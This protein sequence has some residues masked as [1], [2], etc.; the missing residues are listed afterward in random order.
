MKHS[1]TYFFRTAS[2]MLAAVLLTVCL[3]FSPLSVPASAD[4]AQNISRLSE[5]QRD[6][7]RVISSLALKDAYDKQDENGNHVFA[8]MT[9]GQALYE[10]GWARYG[11]SVIANNQFGIKA[12]SSWKGKVFD[13]KTYMVYDSYEA[14][15]AIEGID[16]A[17]HCNLWRAYD[18]WDESVSD[19]SAL[20][21]NEKKYAKLL[22]ASDY[23]DAARKV[24]EAG[25]CSDNG[26]DR[27]LI[28]VIEDYGLDALDGV[29]ADEYG[30][31]G[32]IMDRSRAVIG[33][34][35]TVALSASA[36]PE[37]V[38]P[39]PDPDGD[40]QEESGSE[41]GEESE[42]SAG[43]EGSGE[44]SEESG[45]GEESGD[46]SGDPDVSGPDESESGN[47][48][49]EPVVLPIVWESNAPAV[50][51]VDENGNVTGLSQGIALITATYNGKEAACLVC[52]G[53]NAFVIDSD[54]ALYSLPDP[55]SDS[56]GKVS[57]GMP[58][59][60]LEI[61][62]YEDPDGVDYYFVSATTSKGKL[63]RGYL[64]IRRVYP[65]GQE[66]T[67]LHMET[68]IQMKTGD[69][70]EVAY[71]I[72]PVTAEDKTV[73]WHTSDGSI[74]AVTGDGVLTAV[75][76]GNA[77][78]TATAVGGVTVSIIVNVDLVA[79]TGITTTALKLRENPDLESDYYGVIAGCTHVSV[80]KGP[81]DGWFYIQAE[82]I[83]NKI[84]YGYSLSQYIEV[85]GQLPIGMDAEDPV[86][87]DDPDDP[88][89]PAGRRRSAYVS[90]ETVLNV[91]DSAG[92]KGKIVCRLPDRTEVVIVGEDIRLEDEKTYKNWCQIEFTDPDGETERTGYAAADFLIV[93]GELKDGDPENPD[94]PDP[95]DIAGIY[96]SDD[97]YIWMV[98]PGTTVG[99]FR[100]ALSL[101]SSVL[102]AGSETEREDG[103]R[104][105]TG[106]AVT[107]YIGEIA[108]AS[109]TVAVM[110]DVNGDGL[111]SAQDYMLVKRTVLQTWNLEGVYSLAGSF[112]TP[113]RITAQDYVKVKRMVLGTYSMD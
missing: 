27:N 56:L 45:G 13:N 77:I 23:K 70:H 37:P 83:S 44:E 66:V 82:L 4:T 36:Y 67:S 102:P 98:S 100:S 14:L 72:Y 88:P 16:Y 110:G 47:G 63:L 103:E 64:P 38:A 11:I 2:A 17:K 62:P 69:V 1:R 57:R 43:G 61:T 87:P 6:F 93:T 74:V 7:L 94:D 10:G 46:E 3:P 31:I 97:D 90:V 19:H 55:D 106:D 29:T 18:S 105:R 35:E 22:Q 5:W 99:Q 85:D 52:V 92:T 109:K 89:E 101:R 91:R 25:Y 42:E 96:Q 95:I 20:F 86:Q 79:L 84:L 51:S 73:R 81:M 71:Q 32:M 53:T 68:V 76:K 60:V 108:V 80:L 78:V 41:S 9:A 48:E 113:F 104:I 30:V 26:Y 49:V 33:I 54:T 40:G 12:Y 107:L 65:L 34:D 112:S 75:G 21:Y 59:S 39:D 28:K 111:I 15:A 50:A 58:V 8:S 24:V